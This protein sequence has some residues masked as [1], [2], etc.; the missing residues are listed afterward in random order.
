MNEKI[1]LKTIDDFMLSSEL[2][3]DLDDLMMILGEAYRV[4]IAFIGIVGEFEEEYNK[5]SKNGARE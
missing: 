2:P 3:L 1:R 5:R 4:P